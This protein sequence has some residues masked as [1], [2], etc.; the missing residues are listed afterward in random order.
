[1]SEFKYILVE[2]VLEG[3][4]AQ[5]IPILFPKEL[6]HSEVAQAL[7]RATGD[8]SGCRPVR[9]G[10]VDLKADATHGAS[11]SLGLGSSA[12]DAEWI[13]GFPYTLGLALDR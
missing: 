10:F 2:R 11:E 8:L 9:A 5:H 3:G 12:G 6:M 1:M 7:A 13:N 4:I